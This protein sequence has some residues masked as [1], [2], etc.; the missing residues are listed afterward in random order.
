MKQPLKSESTCGDGHQWF[1][2][3]IDRWKSLS[4][5]QRLPIVDMEASDTRPVLIFGGT[6]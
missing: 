2:N 6:D 1:F 3:L 4:S 5:P